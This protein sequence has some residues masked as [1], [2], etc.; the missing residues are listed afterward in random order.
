MYQRAPV[1]LLDRLAGILNVGAPNSSE[2]L[3]RVP[4]GQSHLRAGVQDG[5][6]EAENVG[7]FLEIA[8]ITQSI[9]LGGW[10]AVQQLPVSAHKIGVINTVVRQG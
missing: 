9:G 8:E 4:D 5:K 1:D 6:S 7:S 2:N 3:K 10:R